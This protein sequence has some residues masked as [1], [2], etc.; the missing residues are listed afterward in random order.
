VDAHLAH[1]AERLDGDRCVYFSPEGTI[2]MDGR[3]GRIRQGFFRLVRRTKCAPWIQPMALS[4]DAL[5][6]GR[7]RVVVRIGEHFRANTSLDRRAFDAALR[8]SV[9]RLAS[10]TPSHLLAR[11]L[12]HGPHAFD[13]PGLA[14]WLAH[15]HAA[16]KTN[17]NSLDPLFEHASFEHIASR[18]LRWLQRKRL[19]AR[20]GEGFRNICPRDARPS[21]RKPANIVRYLDNA[22]A[23][24]VMDPD[25]V[26][27]C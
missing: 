2:S 19:V 20:N 21:W 5:G 14:G 17:G 25:R 18:R 3:F 7:L 6:P 10:I 26:L 24:L 27:P 8:D 12:L 22:L 23:D 1:F 15:S 4:Y 13:A 16:L 9:V 11:F